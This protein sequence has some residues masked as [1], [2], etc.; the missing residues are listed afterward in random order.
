MLLKTYCLEGSCK[1]DFDTEIKF[2][3]ASAKYDGVNLLKFSIKRRIDDSE[4]CRLM[5][6]ITKVLSSLK[7]QGR[8]NFFVKPE[9]MEQNTTE[10]EYITNL[11]GG[12]IAPQKDFLD[13]YVKI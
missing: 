7:K 12:E 6:C 10:A 3:I 8:V 11:F 4:N 1:R 5:S 13:I 9:Q 2:N